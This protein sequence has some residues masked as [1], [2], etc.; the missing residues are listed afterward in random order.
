[1]LQDAA[2]EVLGLSRRQI[3]ENND[4]RFIGRVGAVD[5]LS[6]QEQ[7]L[8]PVYELDDICSASAEKRLSMRW[9][10]SWATSPDVG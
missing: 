9:Q 3:S 8:V 6:G 7:A 5:R 2:K 4:D 1:L 10:K